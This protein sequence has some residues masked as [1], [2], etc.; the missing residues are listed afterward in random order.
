MNWTLSIKS[1]VEKAL[2]KF[3]RQDYEAIRDTIA[4]MGADPFSSDTEKM[5]GEESY[6]RRV[7]SYRIKFDLNQQNRTIDIYSIERRAT[8]TYRKR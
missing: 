5:K 6:K 8:N 4:A 3:P 2:N 1:K 7:R